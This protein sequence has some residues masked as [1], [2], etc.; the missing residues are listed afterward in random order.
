MTLGR[1]QF[2]GGALAGAA[3]GA[4]EPPSG[5]CPRSARP[6]RVLWT[7]RIAELDTSGVGGVMQRPP[8]RLPLTCLQGLVNRTGPQIFL[9]Y[10]RFDE[11]W[12][13]WLRER[14]DVDEVR[15]VNGAQLYERFLG[16][17][18]GLVVTDPAVPGTVN[19]ATMLAGVHGWLPVPPQLLDAFDLPIGMDLRKRWKKNIE[20]YRWFYSA[21]GA[22]MSTRACACLDPGVFELR[23]YL[24]EF[25]VPLIW[26]SGPRDPARSAAASPEEE[27]QFARELFLNLPPN[28]PC[29]GWWDHGLE[30][31]AGIGEIEGVRIASQCAKFQICS[32]WDGYGHPVSNLSVHSGTSAAFRQKVYDPPPLENKVYLTFT[33]TDGDGPNFWRHVFRKLWSDPEHGSVPIGWQLG[34]AAFELIPDIIDYYYRHATPND[35]FVN[36]LTGLGY[37]HEEQYADFL[38]EEQQRKVWDEYI[39]LSSRYFKLFDFTCLTTWR[40]MRRERLERFAELPGLRGMFLNYR[41]METTTIED[42]VTEVKGIPAFRAVAHG[43]GLLDTNTGIRRAVESTVADIR[44]FTVPRRPAFVHVSLTNWAVAIKAVVEIERALGGEYRVVRPDQMA[45]LY[46]LA[47]ARA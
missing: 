29:L 22:R 18:T 15:F 8:Q 3:A 30:A 38:P 39:A 41:R 46:R 33:R 26:V 11:L 42:I 25:R 9:V 36:A 34:P 10:D 28:T 24:V 5:V 27:K 43:G 1:R 40:E 37:I 17:A 6:A 14:G 4:G 32:G 20:A 45:A 19:V 16:A 47:K 2:L 23:D 35:M 12:L 13:N 21:Y 44:R 7:L 31:E